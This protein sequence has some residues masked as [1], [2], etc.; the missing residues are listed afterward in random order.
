M[1]RLDTPEQGRV[2]VI[3]H[4][5]AENDLSAH[6]KDAPNTKHIVLPLVAP[7]RTRISLSTGPWIREKGELLRNGSHSQAAIEKLKLN[8]HPDYGWF[9]QQGAG[10]TKLRL[11]SDHFRT[12]NPNLLKV[13]SIV[14]SVDT[15]VKEGPQNSFT[16]IQV[17]GPRDEGFFLIAEFREQCRLAESTQVLRSIIKLHRP[18]VVLI[19]D[20]ANGTALIDAIARRTT[21]PIVAMN[22]GRYSKTERLARHVPLIRKKP[23]YLPENFPGRDAFVDEIL[24]RSSS[25]DRMDAMTQML[26]FVSS[27]VMPPKPPQRA[28]IAR[29]HSSGRIAV[30]SV[31][32]VSNRTR[33]IVTSFGGRR[34]R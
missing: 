3:A 4:R 29:A 22:P 26:E 18:N 27:N 14:I 11:T 7:H 32:P 34:R 28:L 19:E 12:Y 6:L 8:A 15:A 13:G 2:V 9:Y 10:E 5:L 24:G 1:S 17:W 23:I 33:G 30:A 31:E 16:V 25:T 20:R 21:T